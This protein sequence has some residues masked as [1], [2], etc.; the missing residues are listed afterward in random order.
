MQILPILLKDGYKTTHRVQYA[1]DTTLVYSNLTPRSS[2]VPGCMDVVVFGPQYFA[3]E[4]LVRQ[5]NE[6]F[7][8]RPKDT[9]I[10][11]YKRRIDHYLGETPVDHIAHLHELG[12]LPLLVKALPE[13]SLCPLRVPYLTIRNTHDDFFW[14][15]NMVETLMSNVLWHPITSATTALA[16][17]REFEK[18]ARVTG[19][20]D[21]F[22]KWQGHDFSF[23]GMSGIEAALLSGAA[24]LTSFTGTDTIPAIDLLEMYYGADCEK[25]TIGGSVPATEHSVMS[26]GRLESER[27][28]IRRIIMDVH[29]LGPVSIVC[30]TW[31]FW[32]VV[33][34]IL[35][36]LKADIMSRQPDAWGRP[37]CVVVRPDSGDPVKIVC[38]DAD[39]DRE[40]VEKGAWEC[41]WDTFGGSVNGEN[42]KD[43]DSHVGLIYG[44]AITRERQSQ[45]LGGLAAKGFAPRVVLGMGSYTY[46]Y[47]TR[48]TH[49]Q[50]MK[51]TYGETVS[52]GP[53]DIFKK[54]ATDDGTKNSAT[55]LLRVDIGA[56]GRY[57]L[58]EK[59]TWEEECGGAL[60]PIFLD[61]KTPNLTTLAA[62]RAHIDALVAAELA[63]PA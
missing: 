15:T 9:V 18:W 13:G 47:V 43:L 6:A 48:D 21:W 24:H 14:L 11:Q 35:P 1:R 58:R 26:M 23:R 49:G 42:Y 33:T 61:G 38:G 4:Y 56:D 27:E 32:N 19:V 51:A 7:F 20:P 63:V 10:K 59:V 40:C 8:E 29:P 46:Q 12:Y 53:Q 28:T 25:E 2:R 57:V 45:I 39:A 37:G 62:I 41:L 36:S 30:D 54:P 17:R 31:D 44:D 50:A 34:N 16:Y 60:R 22:V 52:R 5:F 55:G 3:L